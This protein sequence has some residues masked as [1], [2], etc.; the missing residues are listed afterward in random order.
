MKNNVK[1][2]FC[3]KATDLLAEKEFLK[4]LNNKD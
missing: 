3:V 1:E 4:L 2:F